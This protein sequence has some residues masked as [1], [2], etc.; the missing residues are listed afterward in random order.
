MSKSSEGMTAVCGPVPLQ[1][2]ISPLIM[3]DCVCLNRDNAM[4]TERD[5][6]K[7]LLTRTYIPINTAEWAKTALVLSYA[8]WQGWDWAYQCSNVTVEKGRVMEYP[9]IN[10]HYRILSKRSIIYISWWQN[11][12]A[13]A[14]LENILSFVLSVFNLVLF[15][16]PIKAALLYMKHC[17]PTELQVLCFPGQTLTMHQ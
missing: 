7:W 4:L 13:M 5:L 10:S 11:D 6:F 14:K 3:V 2:Y 17:G 9:S 1:I 8:C 16:N 15:Q 12:V